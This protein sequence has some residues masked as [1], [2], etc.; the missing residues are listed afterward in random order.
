VLRALA[1]VV[2]YLDVEL[3]GDG[4]CSDGDLAPVG[5]TRNAMADGVFHDRLQ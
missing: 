2:L 4:R 3:R 1:A 5:A